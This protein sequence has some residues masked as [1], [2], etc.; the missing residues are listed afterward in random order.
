MEAS[1][2]IAILESKM[3][4]IPGGSDRDGRPLLFVK[5]F[6]ET[7]S[8]ATLD[9]FDT[10][11]EYLASVF[12]PDTRSRGLCVVIDATRGPWRIARNVVRQVSTTLGSDIG[13]LLVL[14]H[15]A[16]WDNC[17]R[18]QRDGEPIFIPVSRLAKYIDHSQ[19][20]QE[21]SGLWTYD[22]SRWIANRI[23][24][25]EFVKGAEHAVS[26]LERLRTRLLGGSVFRLSTAE[27]TLGSTADVFGAT[28]QLGQ[29]VMNIGETITQR[30][31]NLSGQDQKDT[32]DRLER[33]M[34]VVRGK[35]T[36]VEDSWLDLHRNIID[37]KIN[38]GVLTDIGQAH[39][40]AFKAYLGFLGFT[41][42]SGLFGDIETTLVREGEKLSDLL[43]MP[44]KDSFGRD[45][46]V[47]YENDIVNIKEILEMTSARKSLFQDSVE[48]QRLTLT[49]VTHIYS[50]EKD[51][52][53]AL[54]WLEDLYKVMCKHHAHVGCTEQEIQVQKEQH[55]VL[56]ETAKSTYEY[57][58]QLL[59]AALSLRQSCKFL[60][61]HTQSLKSCLNKAWDQLNSVGQEQLTRLRV[62]AV[63]Y[64]NVKEQCNQLHELMDLAKCEALG[65]SRGKGSPGG[66]LPP[67]DR[68]LFHCERAEDPW[69]IPKGGLNLT[70]GTSIAVPE[71]TSA[72]KSLFQDSVELQRLTLTQVTHIYSYEKDAAQA[73]QWLEDL[74]KVMCKHH[75]HV[76]CT[77]Q[78]IQVQKDQHQVLQET[79]K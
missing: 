53:Q 49:Q 9:K 61:D 67:N 5:A 24:I 12:S 43:S 27:D 41:A 76:G 78:E 8:T 6:S 77:E 63:F 46:G 14:R 16:F 1:S 48:L 36:S 26:E 17:T 22:H 4:T 31:N 38:I 54:Q 73:L 39:C 58:C 15:D 11:L 57:G 64:R 32:K 44:V 65:S 40:S 18:A 69:S 21:Y 19:L 42:C 45:L 33:L 52:A 20:P 71:M 55:Q 7:Q 28:K 56:Q 60:E 50:Y 23:E 66:A 3:A 79:A 37:A 34:H 13:C 59:K 62:S 10:L 2:I 68:F 74:Y 75:A 47:N 51:A 30:L 29:K 25:E 35:L 70:V 72:R